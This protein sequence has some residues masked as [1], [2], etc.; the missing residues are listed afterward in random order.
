MAACF[1][2]A[3]PGNADAWDPPPPPMA[4]FVPVARAFTMQYPYPYDQTRKN[5]TDADIRAIDEMCQW[6]VADYRTLR[7]QLDAF[8]FNLLHAANDWNA[9]TLNAQ[10]DGV[11]ANVDTTMRFLTPRTTALTISTDYANDMYF[12]VYQGEAFYRLWQE[13]SNVGVGIR[14]RNTAWVYGPSQQRVKH[15]GSKIERS[16]LCDQ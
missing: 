1:V 12:P 15:W 9:G 6:F 14:A 5:V 10:G 7:D 4:D 11:A 16:R 13:L 8:G 3:V 2:A